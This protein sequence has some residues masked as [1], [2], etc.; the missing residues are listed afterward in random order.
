MIDREL[1]RQIGC[2]VNRIVEIANMKVK[3]S[4]TV[5]FDGSGV[6]GNTFDENLKSWRDKFSSEKRGIPIDEDEF[7]RILT[8]R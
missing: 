8:E 7:I 4:L 2:V 3:G 6:I 5:H 1:A